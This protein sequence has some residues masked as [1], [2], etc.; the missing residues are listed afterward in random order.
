M[1]FAHY[2]AVAALAAAPIA[3]AE[4]AAAPEE[5]SVDG[6]LSE[7]AA[8]GPDAL[9]ER[10]A[11]MHAQVEQLNQRAVELRGQADSLEAEA[12]AMQQRVATIEGFVGKVAEAMNPPKEE[13]APEE[14]PAEEPPA[15]EAPVEEAAPEDA[16]NEEESNEEPTE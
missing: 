2:A 9:A 6:V 15:E 14:A 16:S 3:W 10:V 4:E 13:P 11:E 1:R 5:P 12:V 7:L 8:I